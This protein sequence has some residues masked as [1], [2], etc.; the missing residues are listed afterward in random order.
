M[1]QSFK[2]LLSGSIHE[3]A[4]SKLLGSDVPREESLRGWVTSQ[5]SRTQISRVRHFFW[6]DLLHEKVLFC[7]VRAIPQRGNSCDAVRNADE[8]SVLFKRSYFLLEKGSGMT[9]LL[10]SLSKETLFKPK[11]HNWS[12]DWYVVVIKMNEQL[13][14]LFIGIPWFTS[15]GKHFRSPEVK[16]SRTQIG[17]SSTAWISKIP[18]CTFVPHWWETDSAWVDGSHRYSFQME[19]IL[20]SSRT[21]HSSLEDEKAKTEDRPSSSHFSTRSGTIQTKNLAMT[22][23]EN[24]K[25]T[26]SQKVEKYSGRRLLGQFSQSTRQRRIT[27]LAVKVQCR[28]RFQLCASRFHLQSDFPK[29]RTNFIWNTLD[30]SSRTEDCT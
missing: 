29:R 3:T 7:R 15:C 16:N 5:R 1:D 28:N 19:R 25:S 11:S 26:V 21:F 24:D 12:W 13:A 2:F 27:I 6:K 18:Y 20:V 4:K 17:F 9:F 8:S 10:T 22:C 14:A 30:A 23:Q